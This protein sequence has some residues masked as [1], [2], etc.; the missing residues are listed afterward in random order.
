MLPLPPT[1]PGLP[2]NL[3]ASISATT[4]NGWP[5]PLTT[6]PSSLDGFTSFSMDYTSTL[7]PADTT[8]VIISAEPLYQTSRPVSFGVKCGPSAPIIDITSRGSHA[9]DVTQG[10]TTRINVGVI[11]TNGGLAFAEDP[12]RV[13]NLDIV[14]PFGSDTGVKIEA[15]AITHFSTEEDAFEAYPPYM[16][17]RHDDGTAVRMLVSCHLA[18]HPVSLRPCAALSA[19]APFALIYLSLHCPFFLPGICRRSLTGLAPFSLPA[20]NR[21]ASQVDGVNTAVFHGSIKSYVVYLDEAATKTS[22]DFSISWP[23]D[24]NIKSVWLTRV[25]EQVKGAGIKLRCACLVPP[26]RHSCIR[27]DATQHA[28][29]SLLLS[30]NNLLPC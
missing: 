30:Y 2:Q 8:Q 14:V 25:R 22:L 29:F 7:V 18:P 9:C 15:L 20:P 28:H 26:N 11:S 17:T 23:E 21:L 19:A 3:L 4:Q 1:P 16:H 10:E 6:T 12:L 13:Y 27:G 5:L 24:S